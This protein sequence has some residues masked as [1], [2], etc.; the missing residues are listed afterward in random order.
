MCI[1]YR[2]VLRDENRD[3][4]LIVIG[5]YI[6]YAM[7]SPEALSVLLK[8]WICLDD[9]TQISNEAEYRIHSARYPY[10]RIVIDQSQ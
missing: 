4:Q 3:C 2:D 9:S 5:S 10:H 1:L 6:G 7:G 8:G